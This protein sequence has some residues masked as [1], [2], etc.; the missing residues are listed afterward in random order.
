M[1]T[2]SKTDAEALID[3]L[4]D[5]T[6]NAGCLVEVVFR[7]YSRKETLTVAYSTP[8]NHH[9]CEGTVLKRNN[10]RATEGQMKVLGHP[11]LIGDVLE[12]AW[13]NEGFGCL[14]M[15]RLAELWGPIGFNKSLQSIFEEA[16]WVSDDL[17]TV[18]DAQGGDVIINAGLSDPNDPYPETFSPKQSHI[19]ELLQFLLQLGL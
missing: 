1:T 10:E 3:R 8:K 14:E 16:E 12:K 7:P 17:K 11:I 2:L 4:A 18:K 9:F 5:K 13:Q 19:R 6:F 15:A